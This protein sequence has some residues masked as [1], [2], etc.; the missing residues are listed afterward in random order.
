MQ[1]D[2]RFW[3]NSKSQLKIGSKWFVAL[4]GQHRLPNSGHTFVIGAQP[5]EAELTLV[6]PV[7]PF[8]AGDHDGCRPEL[9]EAQHRP[10]PK[11]HTP[12]ILLD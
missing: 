7:E 8:N 11:F 1:G 12:V 9:L 3:F 10:D 6:D 5:T 4:G 2:R